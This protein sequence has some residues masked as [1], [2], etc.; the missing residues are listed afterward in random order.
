MRKGYALE[1]TPMSGDIDLGS[2]M[3]NNADELTGMYVG[4]GMFLDLGE[5]QAKEFIYRRS[6]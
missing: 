3:F 1:N 2:P 4:T 6:K 5:A